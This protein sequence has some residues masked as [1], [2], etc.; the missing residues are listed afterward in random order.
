[1]HELSIACSILEIVEDEIKSRCN[2]SLRGRVPSLTVRI[3]SL[4]GVNSEALSFAWDVARER[5]PFPEADLQIERV[6]A[7]AVLRAARGAEK[8]LI[9]RA[10]V[11]DVF[12]GVRATEQFGPGKKSMAIS[13]RLQ[14]A[15]GT[16]TEAEI[17]AVAGR[18]VAAVAKAT[19]G[20]LRA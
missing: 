14:P 12:Q 3:G 5:G 9:V 6:E 2:G 17:E 7:E 11:F 8:K 15:E 1:M 10:T 20:S 4:S 16:L 18:V 13:I 19:G